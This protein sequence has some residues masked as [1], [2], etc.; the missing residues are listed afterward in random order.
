[1]RE[2]FLELIDVSFIYLNFIK[3]LNNS[4]QSAKIYLHPYLCYINEKS[5]F[6]VGNDKSK[7]VWFIV[8]TPIFYM[9]VVLKV[10]ETSAHLLE[11]PCCQ[12]CKRSFNLLYPKKN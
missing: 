1:M 4:Y 11:A 2:E 6:Y 5:V 8:Y 10:G 12:Y 3:A 7:E 9:L